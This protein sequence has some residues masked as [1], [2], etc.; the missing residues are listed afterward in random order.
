MA[1]TLEAI[2]NQRPGLGGGRRERWPE[3]GPGLGGGRRSQRWWSRGLA[4]EEAT[5]RVGWSRGLSYRMHAAMAPPGLLSGDPD[6]DTQWHT[7]HGP[8]QL[9]SG[10]PLPPKRF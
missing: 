10:T 8:A 5:G 6:T 2:S 9:A 3:W 7:P 1:G 4:W